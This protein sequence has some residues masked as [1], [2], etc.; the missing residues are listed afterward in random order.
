MAVFCKQGSK[1]APPSESFAWAL[2]VRGFFFV[3]F[4]GPPKT[5]GCFPPWFPFTLAPGAHG[6]ETFWEGHFSVIQK[7]CTSLANPLGKRVKAAKQKEGG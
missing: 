3:L 6:L 4:Q 1:V 7:V 2:L 5:H